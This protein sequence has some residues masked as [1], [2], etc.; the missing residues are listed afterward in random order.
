M[1]LADEQP[2]GFVAAL[3]QGE[4]TPQRAA[5]AGPHAARQL[6]DVVSA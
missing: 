4:S 3:D 6:G 5:R 2:A 1:E